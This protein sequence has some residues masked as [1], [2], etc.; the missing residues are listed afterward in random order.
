[1]RLKFLFSINLLTDSTT[2]NLDNFISIEVT[3][4]NI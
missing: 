4:G 1:M 2:V 3:F